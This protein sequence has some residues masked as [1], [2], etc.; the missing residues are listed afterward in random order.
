MTYNE[1]LHAAGIPEPNENELQDFLKNPE[2]YMRDHIKDAIHPT[3]I[4]DC[5]ISFLDNCNVLI[6]TSNAS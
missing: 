5:V 6:R 4:T 2:K 1:A 3:W